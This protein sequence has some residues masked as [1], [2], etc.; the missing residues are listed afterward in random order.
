[1]LAK[2][3]SSLYRWYT[4]TLLHVYLVPCISRGLH[5]STIHCTWAIY[6]NDVGPIMSYIH[7]PFTS[8]TRAPSNIHFKN[9]LQYS[10]KVC[11]EEPCTTGSNC[12][13]FINKKIMYKCWSTFIHGSLLKLMYKCLSTFLKARFLVL[14]TDLMEFARIHEWYDVYG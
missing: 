2:V 9:A 13:L 3:P 4:V 8:M 12:T 5:P 6:V 10:Y 1:M 7:H 14:D 11:N